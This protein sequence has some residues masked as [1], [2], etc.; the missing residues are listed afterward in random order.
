[1]RGD[2]RS[3]HDEAG[4][5]PHGAQ[6]RGHVPHFEAAFEGDVVGSGGDEG[7]PVEFAAARVGDRV[8]A[9]VGGEQVEALAG[10]NVEGGHAVRGHARNG[11]EDASGD[12]ARAQA[13]EGGG[14]G[15]YEDTVDACL[16]ELGGQ[17]GGREGLAHERGD[18]FGVVAP[19]IVAGAGNDAAVVDDGDGGGGLGVQGYLSHGVILL[20]G[21]GL[22]D[23]TRPPWAATTASST[24]SQR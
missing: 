6:Q 22:V 19:R 11:R 4:G 2:R 13:G 24:P 21:V 5:A 16:R 14:A 17:S 23:A 15:A 3:G 18:R 12:E 8:D 20:V 10:D 7:A 9:H 1:M